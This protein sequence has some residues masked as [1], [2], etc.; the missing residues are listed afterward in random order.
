[1]GSKASLFEELRGMRVEHVKP[2]GIPAYR[3]VEILREIAPKLQTVVSP[4]D[5]CYRK[6]CECQILS[7]FNESHKTRAPHEKTI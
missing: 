7:A 6:G 2:D 5:G 1:M 3:A 4:C